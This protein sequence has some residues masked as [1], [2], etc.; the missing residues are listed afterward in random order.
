M[1]KILLFFLLTYSFSTSYAQSE[2]DEKVIHNLLTPHFQYMV[3][4]P[5]GDLKDRFGLDMAPSLM[6]DFLTKNDFLFGAEAQYFFGTKVKEDPLAKIR[7][8]QGFLIGSNRE[9][10]DVQLRERGFYSGIFFGKIFQLRPDSRDRVNGIRVTLGGGWLQH[11]IR[12]QD[13]NQTAPQIA[14]EYQK[15]YD[16]LTGGFA[17]NQF[18]GY[19]LFTHQKRINFSAG[20]QFTQ[21]F[22]KSLR[23]WNFDQN[24][25]DTKSRKDFRTALVFSWAMPFYLGD[26]AEDRY[27]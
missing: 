17:T 11:K 5:G 3:A 16:R 6:L 15:G 20:F 18:I 24:A 14:G 25:A 4:Q 8:P 2:S 23:S 26:K 19:Q 12:L 7:V 1:K 22:T 10:A 27:Y 21:G 9:L 13:D